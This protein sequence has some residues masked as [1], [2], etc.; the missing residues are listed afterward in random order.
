MAIN[1]R[2]AWVIL[3]SLTIA[4]TVVVA[5]LEFGHQL[6][7]RLSMVKL[8]DGKVTFTVF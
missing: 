5:N 8:I 2:S 4:L 7:K 1:A 6:V 3:S